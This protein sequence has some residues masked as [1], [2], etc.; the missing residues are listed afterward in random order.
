ME[1]DFNPEQTA[2]EIAKYINELR[3]N[4]NAFM[5]HVQKRLDSYQGKNFDQ[6]GVLFQS[7]EGKDA[8]EECLASLENMKPKAEMTRM[9]GMDKAAQDLADFNGETGKTGHAGKNDSKMG[10]RLDTHGKWI[11]KVGEII[12]VIPVNGL[13][14]VLQWIIDDGVKDRGDRKSILNPEFTKFGVAC[15]KHKIYKTIAVITFAADYV[16]KDADGK[17]PDGVGPTPT[18]NEELKNTMPD[19]LKVLPEDAEGMSINRKVVT[20]SGVTK[21]IY[22][23]TYTLKDKKGTRTLTK[24]YEGRK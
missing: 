24:E 18:T 4:P 20:E 23:I 13:D 7:A 16:D 2:I 11:G 3:K 5:V 21:T 22:N 10:E 14:F 17:L 19:E 15:A 8:P 9:A 12:G 6:S 1:Q